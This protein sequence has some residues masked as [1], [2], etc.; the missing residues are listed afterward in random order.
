[1]VR[2]GRQETIR[3]VSEGC[4]V[5]VCVSGQLHVQLYKILKQT[6]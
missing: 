4:S 5:V 6:I 1:M 2:V 3:A